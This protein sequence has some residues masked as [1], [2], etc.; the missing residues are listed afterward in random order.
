MAMGPTHY[1]VG[2]VIGVLL[3]A[4]PVLGQELKV[5]GERRSSGPVTSE[6]SKK[7]GSRL[8]GLIVDFA[9]AGV[10]EKGAAV[11][12]AERFSSDMLK[13]DGAGRVQIYAWVT[14]TSA[15]TL[16]ALAGIGLD[17]EL[18]NTDL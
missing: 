5:V 17:V 18:V 2:V 12:A 1:V 8:R 11:N 15:K 6:A 13:V 3:L 7:L 10:E 14:D 9:P 4:G 16:A